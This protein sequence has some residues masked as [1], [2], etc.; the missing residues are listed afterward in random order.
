MGK[1]KDTRKAW[2]SIGFAGSVSKRTAVEL[3][4]CASGTAEQ[5]TPN[6]FTVFS[7]CFQYPEQKSSFRARDEDNDLEIVERKWQKKPI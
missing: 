2:R 6:V 3:F 7:G 5:Q 1:L 4:W